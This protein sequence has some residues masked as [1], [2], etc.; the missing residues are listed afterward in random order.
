MSTGTVPMTRP[1][2]KSNREMF[3]VAILME[4]TK[5]IRI[6]RDG[7]KPDQHFYLNVRSATGTM[8]EYLEPAANYLAAVIGRR[9]QEE[10][11]LLRRVSMKVCHSLFTGI[12]S[13]P[14]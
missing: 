10:N 13:P 7:S 9:I 6:S 12:F 8:E 14:Q 4:C 1:G 3:H 11:V 2:W 5:V